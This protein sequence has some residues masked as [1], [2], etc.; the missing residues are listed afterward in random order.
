MGLITSETQYTSKFSDHCFISGQKGDR[1]DR[2]LPG[3]GVRGEK[4]EPGE[5]G[6]PGGLG[7]LGPQG[8]YENVCTLLHKVGNV[9]IF[10]Q[11]L[12]EIN[13]NTD[14]PNQFKENSHLSWF[15]PI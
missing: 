1:G 10:V 7:P 15:F 2:G 4:G 13:W 3:V 5:S 6:A 14:K 12:M 11:L 8:M 9:D